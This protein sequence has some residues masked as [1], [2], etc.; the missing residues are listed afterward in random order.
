M[1]ISY[2]Y[3]LWIH[4]SQHNRQHDNVAK[5]VQ[6][7]PDLILPLQVHRKILTL[8]LCSLFCVKKEMFINMFSIFNLKINLVTIV[9]IFLRV[10]CHAIEGVIAI[11]LYCTVQWVQDSTIYCGAAL[12]PM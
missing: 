3:Y 9:L 1:I 7:Q 10:Y 12:M 5:L 2:Y 4:Y 8:Q 6:G 11:T